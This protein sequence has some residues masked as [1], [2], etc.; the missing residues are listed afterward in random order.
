[1]AHQHPYAVQTAALYLSSIPALG[2]LGLL[3]GARVEELRRQGSLPS[4]VHVAGP[5]PQFGHDRLP[6]FET[7]QPE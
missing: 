4:G 6:S 3:I 7:L 1:M 5:K 2:I